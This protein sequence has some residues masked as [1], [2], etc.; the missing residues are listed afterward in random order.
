VGGGENVNMNTQ[1]QIEYLEA[2]IAHRNKGK[3]FATWTIMIIVV[4]CVLIGMILVIA[5]SVK[6]AT[7]ETCKV[8]TVEVSNTK[9]FRTWTVW[10]HMDGCNGGDSIPHSDTTKNMSIVITDVIPMN[11][12]CVKVVTHLGTCWRYAGGF[13]LETHDITYPNPKFIRSFGWGG[14][15]MFSFAFLVFGM[16][17][18]A[19]GVIK[20]FDHQDLAK[21]TRLETTDTQIMCPGNGG[22]IMV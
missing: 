13:S 20:Y 17:A 1:Q 5:G 16:W 7:N 6:T 15:M 3:K 22:M 18:C 19:R 10:V 4:V 12:P 14:I 2:N 11:Y 21:I 8:S 9:K